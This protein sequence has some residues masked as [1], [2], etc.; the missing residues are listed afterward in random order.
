MLPSGFHAHIFL[1]WFDACWQG[2]RAHASP[3]AIRLLAFPPSGLHPWARGPALT[4]RS[5]ACRS[6]D[7]CPTCLSSRSGLQPLVSGSAYP[8]LRLSASECLSSFA[9]V[10]GLLRPLLTSALRS[11]RLSTASVAVATRGRS[12]GVSS[13]A[14]R[15]QS[16]NLRFA[17]LM[18]MDFAVGGPLVRRLRLVFGF[19]PSTHAFARCFLQTPPRGGSRPCTLLALHLHQVGQKTFTSKLLSMPSTPPAR[20]AGARAE[21]PGRRLRKHRCRRQIQ[22]DQQAYSWRATHDHT[23]SDIGRTG[24]PMIK[25]A[26]TKAPSSLLNV[27]SIFSARKKLFHAMSLDT[28]R[29]IT[30][31]TVVNCAISATRNYLKLQMPRTL[32]VLLCNT[33]AKTR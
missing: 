31:A 25:I 13:A 28:D 26:L 2:F 14:F 27:P 12:P 32:K 3:N 5:V 19:C 18:D 4:G 9:D 33:H 16:P 6:R 8:F 10:M 29:S 20:C 1:P 22:R 24:N 30:R 21:R 17:S 7:S 11:D 23:T 15:A